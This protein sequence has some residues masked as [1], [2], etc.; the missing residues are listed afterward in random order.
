[1]SLEVAVLADLHLDADSA[2]RILDELRETVDRIERRHDPDRLV[3]LGD[4]VQDVSP[5]AD[6]RNVRRAVDVLDEF[7]TPVRWL[8]GNHD[9]AALS[10]ER[11]TDLLGN[12]RYGADG[13]LVFLDSSAPRLGDGRG[14]LDAEQ[15]AFLD[16]V[17]DSRSNALVFVHHPIH[18]HSL[19]DNYWFSDRPEVAFCGNK[20]AVE[21]MLDDGVRA[22]FNAHLHEADFR[23]ID[24]VAHVTVDAFN[25]SAS[26]RGVGAYATVT[27]AD[28]GSLFVRQVDAEGLERTARLPP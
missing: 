14:E 27:L 16:G 24:G 8:L 11:V 6:A 22:V 18:Y 3:I 1:M 17:L 12:E 10:R 23:M 25:K 19:D 4:V 7:S 21:P 15:L 5:E 2:D 20:G 13:P 26:D 9:V 28:D